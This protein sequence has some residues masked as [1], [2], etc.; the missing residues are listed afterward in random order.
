VRVL[1]LVKG[2]DQGGAES[3][4]LVGARHRDRRAVTHEV[5][6]LSSGHR[7]LVG[8]LEAEGLPVTCLAPGSI[9]DVRWVVRLRRA[10]SRV[11]VVH[12]HSPVP[13][14]AARLL[15]R[16]LPTGSRPKLVTTEHNVWDSHHPLTR[17][18]ERVTFG[19]DDAH[20]AVSEAVRASLPAGRR[21][22]VAVVV[23]GVDLPAVRAQADR[24]AVR[25]ELGVDDHEV[26][27]G[28][29]ANL[30]P[31]KGYPDLLRAARSVLDQ[32]PAARFVAV[33][34]GPQEAEV[35]ALHRDLGLGDRF[36]LLGHRADAVRVLSGF[37][38]FC[39][40]SHHEGLPVALMEAL[41]LGVP[42][43]ATRA[44]G[45]PEL[46]TDGREGRLVPVGAV[47]A[48]ATALAAEVDDDVT[49]KAHADA[50]AQAGTSLSIET[51]VHHT[52]ALY[53]TLAGRAG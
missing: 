25:R 7:Q 5:A 4:L 46:V 36:T 32:A 47:A 52:E 3:L 33:G 35:A 21:P 48:L 20:L 51:S 19:L 24:D 29:I 44:G 39:L 34:R 9:L 10:M 31:Q 14:V 50:A 6:Y 27:V 26:L 38:V 53:R 28:T 17:L 41:A 45:I 11:E 16:T 15:A 8:D 43:V 49:R 1:T 23:A 30:R 22:Q 2:L 42:V 18:A 37:D 12:A 40:A 13:A